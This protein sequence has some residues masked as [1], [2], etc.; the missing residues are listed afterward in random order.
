MEAGRSTLEVVIFNIFRDVD[1]VS[2]CCFGRIIL[3]QSVGQDVKPTGIPDFLRTF[4]SLPLDDLLIG[5]CLL[6]FFIAQ[7]ISTRR[8]L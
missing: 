6:R 3:S 1:R 7:G 5:D 2:Y 4:S 8:R